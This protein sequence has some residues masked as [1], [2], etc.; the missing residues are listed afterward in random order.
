MKAARFW[1]YPAAALYSATRIASYRLPKTQLGRLELDISVRLQLRGF[2]GRYRYNG[3][4]LQTLG[5]GM[6]DASIVDALSS[7]GVNEIDSRGQGT[8][9]FYASA[10]VIIWHAGA[11]A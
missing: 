2:I 6:T 5:A 8:G 10:T 3:L 7:A 4:C 1:T 9:G 11:M